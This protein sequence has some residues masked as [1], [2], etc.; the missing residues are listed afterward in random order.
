M[1]K[2]LGSNLAGTVST[3]VSTDFCLRQLT[4]GVN[5][6][7]QKSTGMASAAALLVCGMFL[8]T[9]AHAGPVSIT[10]CSTPTGDA[11]TGSPSGGDTEVNCGDFI[12]TGDD[13]GFK[14]DGGNPPDQIEF[15]G[16]LLEL[17]QEIDV[18]G[19]RWGQWEVAGAAVMAI[20]GATNYALYDVSALNGAGDWSV[21]FGVP[22]NPGGNIPDGSNLRFYGSV[23]VPAPGALAL[24]GV[25]LLLVGAVRRRRTV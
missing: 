16:E 20:K 23:P 21:Y 11:A 2:I 22:V 14:N 19:L 24:L 13:F 5:E 9:A 3:K 15:D 1:D 25:G 6:M 4:A 10:Y 17:I 7:I 18:E 12:G 8:G